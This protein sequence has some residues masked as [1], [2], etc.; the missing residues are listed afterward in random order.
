MQTVATGWTAEERDT[1]RKIVASTQVSWKKTFNSTIRFF[2]IGVSTIG[3]TD[4]IPTTDS[5]P[6]AW[7]K[8]IFTDESAYLTNLS[9]ERGLNQPIGGVSKAIADFEFDNT[10]G[11]FTPRFMGGTN[12]ETYTACLLY[13]SRCV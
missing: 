11:R 8:Y 2:A 4:I 6:S 12:T 5:A 13:T 3:G 9:Y 7:S 10:S 1:T